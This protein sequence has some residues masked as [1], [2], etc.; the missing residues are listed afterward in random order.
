MVVTFPPLVIGTVNL[1]DEFEFATVKIGDIKTFL[2]IEIK[3]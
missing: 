3:L 2:F 1:D